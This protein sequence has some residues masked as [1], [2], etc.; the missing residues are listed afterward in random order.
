VERSL[1][2]I[3][4][5]GPGLHLNGDKAAEHVA[6]AISIGVEAQRIEEAFMN[7]D[8]IA[9]KKIWEVIDPLRRSNGHGG[10]QKTWDEILKEWAANPPATNGR[11]KEID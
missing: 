2:L 6:A 8:S 4:N 5:R 3:W 11:V 10:K 1:A 9:G 7:H